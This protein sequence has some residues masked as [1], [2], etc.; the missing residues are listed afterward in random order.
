MGHALALAKKLELEPG[1]SLCEMG[2]GSSYV[3]SH[4]APL[5]MPGGSIYATCGYQDE[6][7]TAVKKLGQ[8]GLSVHTYLASD[9]SKFVTGA[10]FVVDGG[11]TAQ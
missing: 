11:A 4:L 6:C 1:M 9:E 7:D 5:V 2:P 8:V 3:L 10:E